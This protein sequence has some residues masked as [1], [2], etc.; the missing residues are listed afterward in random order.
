MKGCELCGK[1]E[2]S[3]SKALVEGVKF[4]VCLNCKKFGKVIEETTAKLP[5]RKIIRNETAFEDV[6]A[7]YSEKIKN[8]RESTGLSQKELA[9]KL[10]EKET[11]ISKLEQ[12]ALKPSI[13]L[14]KKL[15]KAL[16]LKLIISEKII[17]AP[18]ANQRQGAYTIGHFI[19]K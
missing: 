19:K 13:Q 15:E 4:N 8:S 6:A 3:L 1:Q 10:N 5:E 2:D 16:G 11:V 18:A 17:E 14:A 9:L 12:G 7:D